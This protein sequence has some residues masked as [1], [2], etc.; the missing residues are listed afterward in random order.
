MTNVAIGMLTV[1]VLL[2]VNIGFI[3]SFF[4]YHSFTEFEIFPFPV[5]LQQT[6]EKKNF[7]IKKKE[8]PNSYNKYS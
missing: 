8:I 3:I 5:I 1:P 2:S 7:K 4:I 6:N